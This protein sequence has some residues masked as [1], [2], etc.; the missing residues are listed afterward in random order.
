MPN[1]TTIP[2]S[3][4]YDPTLFVSTLDAGG[5]INTCGGLTLVYP[6]PALESVIE[7]TTPAVI[8]A[9]A[10]AV[11]PS[12]TDCAVFPILTVGAVEYPTP[13]EEIEIE[14]IVPSPETIA[15]AAAPVLVS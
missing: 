1:P 10:T 15:V 8:D 4:A 5:A 13:P 2:L 3:P 14:D 6:V 9:V 7:V 12:P 11:V